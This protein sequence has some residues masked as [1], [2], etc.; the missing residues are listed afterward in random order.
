MNIVTK[1]PNLNDEFLE[2]ARSL[3]DFM[4]QNYKFTCEPTIHFLSDTENAQKILGRTGFYNAEEESVHV[5][6]TNRHPKDILRSLSHELL[7][8]IQGC[9]GM[10]DSKRGDTEG[11]KDPNY[12]L[13]DK[14]LRK[15][16]LDAFKRGNDAFRKW[17]AYIKQGNIK[18]SMSKEKICEAKDKKKTKI[19][20]K[21]LSRY[22]MLVRK[23]ADDIKKGNPDIPDPIKFG[24]AAK[25]A[26]KKLKIYKEDSMETLKEAKQPEEKEV[27]VNEALKNSL[28]YVEEDRP[29][30]KAYNMRDEKI[31]NELL[32]KFKIKK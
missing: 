28:Y 15:I 13:H 4:K 32:K 26:K 25:Q 3:Y 18:I 2:L 31:Y 20:K 9:E 14:F 30:S 21:K 27:E 5:Y 8:H 17:E 29:L 12:F 16:E 10:V 19:P 22:K 6:I 7:H 24:T 23:I 11:T 1:D